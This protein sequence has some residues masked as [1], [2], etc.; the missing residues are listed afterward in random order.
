MTSVTDTTADL[1]S[2]LQAALGPHYRLERS[3]GQGGMGVVFLAR[4]L[5]LDRQVAVKV[6]HPQRAVH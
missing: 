6:V 1:Q 5:T 2:R 4:D 3:L